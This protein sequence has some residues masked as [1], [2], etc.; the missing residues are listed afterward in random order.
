VPD[1]S[2][3]AE[4]TG[5][6]PGPGARGGP[7]PE[8]LTAEGL[9]PTDLDAGGPS[10]VPEMIWV[11]LW[12]IG[13]VI[14]VTTPPWAAIILYLIWISFALLYGLRGWPLPA[15]LRLVA[16]VT[17]STA[18]AGGVNVIR[19]AEPPATL[20][21]VPL[22]AAIF[23]ALVWQEHRRR[24]ADIA[25]LAVAAENERLLAAQRRFLQDASHQLRTPITIALGHAELLAGELASQDGRRDIQV[26]VGEL[27]RLRSL[28]ERLLLIATSANPDFLRP[29]P[30]ELSLFAVDLLGRWQPAAPRRWQ[31]GR[32]D[33]AVVWADADRLALALDA[34]LE[35]AVQHTGPGDLIQVSVHAP[36][37]TGLACVLVED[38]GTGIEPAELA[39]I[40]ERFATGPAGADRRGTGLGLPLVQAIARGHG[41]DVGVHSTVGAGSRFE[42]RLPLHRAVT[43]PAAAGSAATGS[44]EPAVAARAPRASGAGR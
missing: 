36:A 7:V 43:G 39:H 26:V 40:F 10:R 37:A 4:L 21:K 30:V 3:P 33:D 2:S 17:L 6:A 35:N 12:L 28:S 42:F 34:L 24:A 19:G 5:P 27:N 9:D 13:V 11:L 32:L 29:E 14:M 31:I 8:P 38:S 15:A 16:L 20:F 25:H 22:V 18:V 44:S 41:G 23:A 1:T